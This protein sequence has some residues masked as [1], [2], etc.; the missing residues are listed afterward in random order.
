MIRKAVDWGVLG[1]LVWGGWGRQYH[2]LGWILDRSRHSSDFLCTVASLGRQVFQ[3]HQ[4]RLW[5]AIRPWSDAPSPAVHLAWSWGP[6]PTQKLLGFT[7][8]VYV[9]STFSF[10]VGMRYIFDFCVGVIRGCPLAIS[11]LSISWRTLG[12]E[13]YLC[14]G[15]GGRGSS[16]VSS[17]IVSGQ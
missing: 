14:T 8:D 4:W 15:C 1:V 10:G 12:S 17:I 11:L 3:G 5:W 6:S 13:I 9:F 7:L 2:L 16:T